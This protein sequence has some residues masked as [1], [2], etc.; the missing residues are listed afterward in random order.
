MNP[1][2]ALQWERCPDGVE[3]F[4]YG[5][6][7]LRAAGMRSTIL[8]DAA[9]KQGPWFRDRSP[10]RVAASLNISSLEN[11]VVISFVNARDDDARCRFFSRYGFLLPGSE[12]E[13]SEALD[14]QA[15]FERLLVEAGSADPDAAAKAVN[16]ALASHRGF[17]LVATL[18]L[19]DGLR[20]ALKPQSLF[21][22]ILMEV[23]MVALHGARLATCDH[24]GELFLTGPLTWRRSHARFHAD[25]CR[26]AAMRSRNANRA[27]K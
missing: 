13:R 7:P 23:A 16:M 20:L 12:L 10:E 25:R 1:N 26:V 8:T 14:T 11:P 6:E 27:A 4:D 21:A 22:F 19:D 15:Y 24:C 5:R 3:L 17:A 18:E 2:L 9:A